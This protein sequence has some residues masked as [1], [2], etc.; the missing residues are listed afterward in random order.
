MPT[1]IEIKA[2]LNNQIA[3]HETAAPVA[4]HRPETIQQQDIFFCCTGA[5]LRASYPGT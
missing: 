4:W 5:R 1:N 3:A 2:I